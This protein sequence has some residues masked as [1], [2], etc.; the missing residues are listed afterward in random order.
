MTTSP[1]PTGTTTTAGYIKKF[2][3]NRWVQLVLVAIALFAGGYGTG[4]WAQ[5]ER[6]V[7]KTVEKEKLV[8]KIV[9]QDR[10]VEKVVYVKVEAKHRRTETRTETKPDGTK[11]ETKVTD[12]KTDTKVD[13]DKD[14]TEEKIVYRDRVVEKIVEKEKLVQAKKIDWLV[15]AGVGISVPTFLGKPQQGIPGMRGSV[16]Q[17]GVDRRVIGP[18]FLGVFGDSQGTVGLRATGAF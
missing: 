9:Y 3:S 15:H 5:P 18:L 4:R 14:K 1:I 11:V 12:V 7:E 16:V 6:V 13:V 2:F 17:L 8:D 10:V